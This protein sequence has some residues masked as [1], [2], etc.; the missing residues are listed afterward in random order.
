MI[1]VKLSTDR[2]LV[3]SERLADLAYPFPLFQKSV[4]YS[5]FLFIELSVDSTHLSAP[6]LGMD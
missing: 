1:T 2:A 5:T 6:F 4:D 3:S